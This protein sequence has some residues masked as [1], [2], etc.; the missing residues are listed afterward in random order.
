MVDRVSTYQV[1]SSGLSDLQRLNS[2]I[3]KVQEQISSGRKV[4]TPADDPVAASRVLELD[5]TIAQS[6][7]FNTNNDAA[8]SRLE[9]EETKLDAIEE[10]VMR[11]RELATRAGNGSLTITERQAIAAEIRQRSDEILALM[12]SRD[13]NG[14]YMFSG[15]SGNTEPFERLSGGG[16]QWNGD[17]GQR[18]LQIATTTKVATSDSGKRLFVDVPAAEPS[19]L[20]RANP[21]N[22]GDGR[23]LEGVVIDQD[24]FQSEL[25]PDDAIIVFNNPQDI[26]PPSPNYTVVNKTTKKPIDG[27]VNVPFAQARE[28]PFG[29]LQVQIIGEPSAGDT[30]VVETSNKQPLLASVDRLAHGLETLDDSAE[31][32]EALNNLIANSLD[33]LE[34]GLD[35]VTEV[36]AQVGARLN[37]LE[38]TK[39]TLED[40]KLSATAVRS[41]LIDLD[42]AE[43]ITRFSMETFVLQ[44]SQQ[45][46][47]KVAGLSLFNYL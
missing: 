30:F 19:F 38:T 11:V 15:F 43:A 24:K 31:Q 12:N 45:T 29:G 21:I 5:A 3:D 6:T 2:R 4:V 26:D 36:R 42:Y 13:S 14:D 9:Q 25:Y 22:R 10:S 18:F 47:A 41:E 20:T 23:I 1:F 27:Q 37:V 34:N 46:F 7:Q 44:A 28:I 17:E 40:L 32:S 35:R 33:N 16:V 39:N 8:R